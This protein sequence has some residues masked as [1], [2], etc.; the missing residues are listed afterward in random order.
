[1][2]AVGLFKNHFGYMMEK[3]LEVEKRDQLGFCCNS[4][5]VTVAGTSAELV[6]IEVD[7]IKRLR[8]LL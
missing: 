3:K 5:E 7:E 2:C 4:P 1:M 6:K 8:N